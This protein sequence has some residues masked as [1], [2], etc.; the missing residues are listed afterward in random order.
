MSDLGRSITDATKFLDGI[1]A[2]V[3]SLF[4]CVSDRLDKGGWSI[5]PNT[6]AFFGGSRSPTSLTRSV[7][8]WL[9][10]YYCRRSGRPAKPDK[11]LMPWAFLNIY[12]T[13]SRFDEPVAIWGH[14][15]F[16]NPAE[17]WS[18][19][20]PVFA[21][22][23]GPEFLDLSPLCWKSAMITGATGAEY[24]ACQ[25]VELS[26]A[27]IVEGRIVTPWLE[28]LDVLSEIPAGVPW[29]TLNDT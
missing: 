14:I 19:W 12:F 20:N 24:K 8:P 5:P 25:L 9:Y 6:S 28:R 15:A 3:S 1:H 16:T 23:E 7:P 17:S 22:D 18:V 26:S 2:D 27:A 11:S 10:A 4:R 21:T 13:P 29:P